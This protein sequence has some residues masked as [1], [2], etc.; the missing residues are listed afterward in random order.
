MNTIIAFKEV[1]KIQEVELDIGIIEVYIGLYCCVRNCHKLSGLK[2][3]EH[4]LTAS[5]DLKS[6]YGLA[7]SSA[8]GLTRLKARYQIGLQSN[9][10]V[11]TLFQAHLLWAEFSSIGQ[12]FLL[13]CQVT[14]E[15][16][17]QVLKAVHHFLHCPSPRLQGW[18]ENSP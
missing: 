18:Q 13:S 2:Q 3:Q 5:T 17:C 1:Y 15:S 4:Y 12:S 7:G 14:I 6:E 16:H 8:Q 11:N 9:L 10:K